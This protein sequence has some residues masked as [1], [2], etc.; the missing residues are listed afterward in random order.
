MRR[1]NKLIGFV[2]VLSVMVLLVGLMAACSDKNE[3][4]GSSSNDSSNGETRSDSSKIAP[5]GIT[6]S[7]F[8]TDR[9][10]TEGPPR[11]DWKP[12]TEIAEKTGVRVKF[13]SAPP[14][15]ASEKRQI[16]MATN[17]VT[18]IF[19]TG[20]MDFRAHGPDGVFLNLNDYMDIA[21]NLKKFYEEYPEAKALAT[22]A[23]GGLYFMPKLT[24]YPGQG[25]VN[26]MWF[27]RQDI[28]EE[29]QLQPPTNTEELYTLL[30]EL[31][32]LYP[33]SYPLTFISTHGPSGLYTVMAR[34]FTGIEGIM[35]M[36]PAQNKYVFA[37]DQEGYLEAID[38]MKKLYD[39][40]L[41]DPEFALLTSAQWYE[42]LETGQ[43]LVSYYWKRT[44]KALNDAG[45]EIVGERYNINAIPPIAANGI[46]NYQFGRSV[47]DDNG[48]GI[49]AK[50]KDKEKAVRFLD[51][52]YSEEG[53]NYLNLGIEGETYTFDEEGTPRYLDSFFPDPIAPL[54][55]DY[56]VGYDGLANHFALLYVAWESGL[57]ELELAN[58][59]MYKAHGK[60]PPKRFVKTEEELELEKSRSGNLEQYLQGEITKF[61]MGDKPLNVETYGQMLEQAK[62]LGADQLVDMYNTAYARTY[63][64]N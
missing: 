12:L 51:Y 50:V 56:G 25:G 34:A 54:R 21:P 53:I 64:D 7:W 46:E 18:D 52:L 24:S 37:P 16:M 60:N 36:D 48:L 5:E 63:G 31:K 43:S 2:P 27:A 59:E 4:A 14:E 19:N 49:S 26:Y 30:K 22:A 47:I 3:G 11:E 9:S 8:V 17:S 38:Y 28:M 45:K 58:E 41:L 57:S 1:K 42:R 33:D 6:F 23:D 62:K 13:E 15:G 20:G 10:N 32:A 61:I 39:E 55:T 29:H 40:G 44:M 35:G